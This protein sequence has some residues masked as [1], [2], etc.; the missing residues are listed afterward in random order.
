M[1]L[2]DDAEITAGLTT[3]PTWTLSEDKTSISTSIE[4]VDFVA[5]LDLVNLIGHEAEQ[6]GHHPDID[7]RWNTVTLVLS[8]HSEGG[9]TQADLNL[10]QRINDIAGIDHSDAADSDTDDDSDEG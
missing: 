1:T 3:L 9:L 6:R 7:I 4:L 8:S 2:L 5:A 10:A